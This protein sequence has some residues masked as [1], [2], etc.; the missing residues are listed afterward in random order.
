M[1]KADIVESLYGQEKLSKKE[2]TEVV[3]FLLDTLKDALERGDGVKLSGF[4]HFQV[5]SKK[6]RQ[7]RNPK[8]GET[9]EIA[10]RKVLVF[11][12]SQ[13]LKAALNAPEPVRAVGG[14]SR[15]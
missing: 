5:R 1:T 11:R 4:G 12:P 8:T 7:G 10:A 2:A 15:R 3:D 14:A 9:M 13:V 6:P